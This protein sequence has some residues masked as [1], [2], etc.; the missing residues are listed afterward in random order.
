MN[1]HHQS[2][3]R[4][5]CG[6]IISLAVGTVIVIAVC[7]WL[8][9]AVQNYWNL[10]RMPPALRDEFLRLVDNPQAD[11]ARFHYIVDTW[12]G[13]N[14]S[15]PSIASGDWLLL[16]VLVLVMIPFIVFMG[17][18]YARPLSAQFSQL[19]EAAEEVTQGEFGRQAELVRE[20]PAEM[21]RFASDFNA[22]TRQLAR[23]EKELRA[24]HVAMAHELRS[25]LT[26]AMGRL[27][28]MLDGVF[29]SDPQQ[30]AMVMKQLQLLNRLTDELH[31]LSLADAGQ[32]ILDREAISLD[33]LLRERAAWLKPQADA[34]G[35]RVIIH[36]APASPLYADPLRLGQVFTVL[37]E[38]TLRYGKPGGR[39]DIRLHATAEGYRIDFQDDGPGVSESF[40]PVMF[41]RFTRAE[42]SR[43]RHSGG[44]GLGLSIARAICQ[45]HGGDIQAA[46]PE[47][48]G[49]WIGV[50]L[51]TVDASQ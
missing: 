23:Y 1:N 29:P 51:P 13:L 2:L 7:M 27:Q 10:H 28:G 17:L 36:A 4:W 21:V 14:Y 38:N 26:A 8:R 39:L 5:I 3:W 46:L 16:S 45:A 35:I 47:G 50:T 30:L 9:F 42:T 6:R 22:M 12:W 32:L 40:L 49:L 37:M 25:P 24:S 15:T 34:A 20:A 48:G 43:A 33:E 41:E 18:K 19:R 44:S 11:P 31:L